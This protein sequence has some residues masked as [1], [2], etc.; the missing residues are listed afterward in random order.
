MNGAW[1]RICQDT[2]MA[3]SVILGCR[4]IRL[5]RLNESMQNVGWGSRNSVGY[6]PIPMFRVLSIYNSDYIE[7]TVNFSCWTLGSHSGHCEWFSLPRCNTVYSCRSTPTFWRCVLPP[8]PGSK[9]KPS[10]KPS[11]S[12]RQEERAA[13]KFSASR[14]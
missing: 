14:V 13:Y 2:S 8:P 6:C 10:K 9:C 11:R 3:N 12:R 4:N 1:V 5:V 7:I